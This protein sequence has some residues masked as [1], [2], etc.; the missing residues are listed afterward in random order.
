MAEL[1]GTWGKLSGF[2]IPDFLEDTRDAI[3]SVAE[4]LS[5]YLGILQG[6]LALV[7]SFA[8]AYLDPIRALVESLI[9]QVKQILEDFRQIGLYITG[10]WNLLSFPYDE[11]KGGYGAFERRMVSR[12]TDVADP[13]RPDVSPETTVFAVFFYKSVDF[14]AVDRGIAFINQLLALFNQIQGAPSGLPTP[15]IVSIKYGTQAGG[16]TENL[17]D[18]VQVINTPNPDTKVKVSWRIN[19]PATSRTLNPY[20]AVAPGGFLVTFST[21]PNGIPLKFARPLGDTDKKKNDLGELEQPREYGNALDTANRPIKLYGGA[22]MMIRA[23]LVG[24]NQAWNGGTLKDGYTQVY[25]ELPYAE[26]GVVPLELLQDGDTF[27]YQRTFRVNPTVIIRDWPNQT[28]SLSLNQSD[29]PHHA[30]CQKNADGT[31]TLVDQ[32]VPPTLFVRVA[33]CSSSVIGDGYVYDMSTAVVSGNTPD[34]LFRI[35]LAGGLTP[36]DISPWSNPANVDFPLVQARQLE[37]A[38]ATALLVLLLSRSDYDATFVGPVTPSYPANQALI[39]TGMESFQVL[40]DLLAPEG[41]GFLLEA[42]GRTPQASRAIVLERVSRLAKKLIADS[43]LSASQRSFI[44]DRCQTLRTATLYQ[45]V[46][47][48]GDSL[49]EWFKDQGES[50]TLLGAFK[51]PYAS[52]LFRGVCTNP[53]CTE[54]STPPKNVPGVFRHY[55][56]EFRTVNRSEVTFN[57]ESNEGAPPSHAIVYEKYRDPVTFGANSVFNSYTIPAEATSYVASLEAARV[58]ETSGDNAPAFYC[59]TPSLQVFPNPQDAT[60]FVPCR[61]VFRNFQDG[62]LY[63]EAAFVLGAVIATARPN[64]DGEWIAIRFLDA[65]PSIDGLVQVLL[66]WLD[67]INESVNT[68]TDALV[69]YIEF[70]EGRLAELQSLIRRINALVQALLTFTIDLPQAH[71]MYL[72]AKGTAGVTQ[73]LLTAQNKPVDDYLD[74]GFGLCVVAPFAPSFLTD[75]FLIEEG[76]PDDTVLVTQSNGGDIIGDLPEGDIVPPDEEPD[77]L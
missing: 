71:A 48:A 51:D 64:Q 47:G 25:G 66:Q 67:S 38:V 56:E 68:V 44:L 37:E 2:T 13:T 5:S 36:P 27:Y 55:G 65:F 1:G 74:Y 11:L 18:V 7:K 29:M 19:Q 24:Y 21:V 42:K 60:G 53:Y 9:S 58:V 39:P 40:R 8:S 6:A 69:A 10:D 30:T 45:M 46:T 12:L 28:F 61:W 26:Q 49:G 72:L 14:T 22:E 34:Q 43:G 23:G 77:V 63:G 4:L 32:G 35:A 70:L 54:Y 73:G 57:P 59:T 62:V 3:N 33:S 52:A 15:K 50:P 41:L 17:L 75:M 16:F 76:R 20:P 31:V